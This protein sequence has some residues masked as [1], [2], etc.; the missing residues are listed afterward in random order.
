MFGGENLYAQSKKADSLKN[1]LRGTLHDTTRCDVLNRLSSIVYASNPDTSLELARQA[2]DLSEKIDYLKGVASANNNIGIGHYVKG[3][4]KLAI[5]FNFKSL[6]LFE[7]GLRD[8]KINSADAKLG[9]G[10]AYNNIGN[11]YYRQ[12]DA[13]TAL[14]NYTKSLKI[15]FET[16]NK[17]GIASA[18]NN[19]GNIHAGNGEYDKAIDFYFK[20]ADINS[21]IGNTGWQSN[22]LMNVGEIYFMKG[23]MAHA[24][25]FYGK[26]MKLKETINDK[27][28]MA[29]LHVNISGLFLREKKAAEARK[30]A[31]NGLSLARSVSAKPQLRDAY[32]QLAVIDST[33]GDYK[34]AFRYH[35]LYSVYKDSVMNDQ[36]N[37][38]ILKKQL[39]HDYEKKEA[40][41]KA[42]QEKQLAVAEVEKKQQ[43]LVLILISC[44]LGLVAVFAVFVARS[45]SLTRKQKKI[46]EG[47][48]KEILDSI[49][50]AK[51]IQTALI[52]SEKDISKALQ[53]RA[54]QSISS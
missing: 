14:E 40:Q 2:L 8:G 11:I 31:L 4:Y 33:T 16:G 25:E 37:Q 27:S 41:N 21:Q 1:I 19:I 53:K 10:D 39:Q 45:L 35:E 9:M 18:S 28:G 20:A 6:E 54:K 51:R 22:N 46:I 26:S 32:K 36:T 23:D 17:K 29:M 42:E 52:T 7:N 49:H 48:Q 3:N 43:R 38:A 30:E 34:S 5:D 24:H 44:V 50:Y 15:W 47:K 13:S 12:G